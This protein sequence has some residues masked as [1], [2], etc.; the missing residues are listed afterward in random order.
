[1]E[2][3]NTAFWSIIEIPDIIIE[4]LRDPYEFRVYCILKKIINENGIC[5]M[6][7]K[8]IALMCGISERKFQ[9]VKKSL[10]Q[11]KIKK[12]PLITVLEQVK[13]CGGRDTDSIF[14]NSI[15]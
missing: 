8:E 4:L 2:H 3:K 9:N 7:N 14:I 12:I 11:K 5:I 15:L 6:N 10:Q 1:M 13:P